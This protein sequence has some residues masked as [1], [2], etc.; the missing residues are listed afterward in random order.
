VEEDRTDMNNTNTRTQKRSRNVPLQ[1][2]LA[3]TVDQEE[4]EE[5]A[6]H[7]NVISPATMAN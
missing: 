2:P 3:S 4:E 1:H 7:G 5:S 6:L